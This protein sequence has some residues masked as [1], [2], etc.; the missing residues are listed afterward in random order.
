MTSL[1]RNPLQALDGV[2]RLLGKPVAFGW[3]VQAIRHV[4]GLRPGELADT[5]TRRHPAL[6]DGALGHAA[7]VARIPSGVWATSSTQESLCR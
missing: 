6:V 2:E 1:T 7:R 5:V 4:E 3:G